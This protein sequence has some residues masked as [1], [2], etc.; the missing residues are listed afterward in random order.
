MIQTMTI[1]GA[2][3]GDTEL[4]AD[5]E[6]VGCG[7]GRIKCP[8]GGGDGIWGKFAPEITGR[9]SDVSTAKAPATFSL[10]PEKDRAVAGSAAA[11]AVRCSS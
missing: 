3:N 6:D 1:Y 10:V 2:E 8:G 11:L 9:I 5:V 4:V 7:A